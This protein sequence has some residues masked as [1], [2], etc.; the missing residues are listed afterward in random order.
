MDARHRRKSRRAAHLLVQEDETMKDF[1]AG[2]KPRRHV[3]TKS[4]LIPLRWPR[5]MAPTYP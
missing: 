3:G 2:E 1:L 5:G 4:N